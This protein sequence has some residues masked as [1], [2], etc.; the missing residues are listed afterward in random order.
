MTIVEFKNIH[1]EYRAKCMHCSLIVTRNRNFES[2]KKHFQKSFECSFVIQFEKT[3]LEIS[4]TIIEISKLFF[5]CRYRIFRCNFFM[6]YSKIQ[7]VLR[8]REFCATI[9]TM[10]TSISWIRFVDS[11]NRMLSKFY[12][13]M[14]SKTKQNRQK[15]FKR[16]IWNFDYCIFCE[17]FCEIFD[18]IFFF[19][20]FVF[21]SS[22]YHSCLNCFAFF[23]SLIRLLQHIQKIIC[24]K[25]VCKQCEKI[26]E[27]KNKFH[28]HIRQ[29]HTK[30]INK[31]VS[32]RNCNRE[33]NKISS[34]SSTISQSISSISLK[35]ISKFSI[36]KFVTFLKRSKNSFISFVI[37][38]TIASTTSKRLHFS[39]FI[40][41]FILKHVKIA[42]TICSSI[43]F[44]TFSSKF[45]KF[46]FTIDNL[47]R[48]FREKSKSFDLS[49]HQKR[50]SFSRN[51][52]I[53]YQSR[54]I[55]YFLF[56][57]NQKSSIN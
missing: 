50:R 10:S 41:K 22:Q 23:S 55:A 33:K 46:H 15:E 48:M 7:F 8:N 45:Q 56:A 11:V 34:I 26:F 3:K 9:S 12:F 52:D 47:I 24:F 21:F 27:L 17:I 28:E 37:F 5:C 30:K 32:K 42:S 49:Q 57:I 18:S 40:F 38:A 29:H 19:V 25:V 51:F 6:R 53:F 4:K 36:F 39:L 14:I 16:I 2:F 20:S 54:I 44:A 1:D 43:S 35:T 13:H 31:I